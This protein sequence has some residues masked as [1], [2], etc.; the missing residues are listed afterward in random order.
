MTS[1][2]VSAS[3]GALNLIGQHI[4]SLRYNEH[5][6]RMLAAIQQLFSRHIHPELQPPQW[7]LDEKG[8]PMQLSAVLDWPEYIFQILQE[9]PP[10]PLFYY[11][12]LFAH[13]IGDH[14]TQQQSH[15]LLRRKK[16]HYIEQFYMELMHWCLE[17]FSSYP[18]GNASKEKILKRFHYL[19]ACMDSPC[20]FEEN[21]S[22]QFVSHDNDRLILKKLKTILS[23]CLDY[24]DIEIA[25]LS[26]REYLSTLR[27]HLQQFFVHTIN[28]IYHQQK[29]ETT[30]HLDVHQLVNPQSHYPRLLHED[31]KPN[32]MNQFLYDIMR[33]LN[34]QAFHLVQSSHPSALENLDI[35]LIKKLMA[36][37]DLFPWMIHHESYLSQFPEIIKLLYLFNQQYE[38]LNIVFDLTG[39]MGEFW[40][41]THEQGGEILSKVISH[42]KAS[43][44]R[45]YSSAEF[46]HQ[47]L[48]RKSEVY[49]HEKKTSIDHKFYKQFKKTQKYFDQIKNN[50][51]TIREHCIFIL[52][53]VTSYPKNKRREINEKIRKI[54]K[55]LNLDSLSENIPPTVEKKP[56][57]YSFN[58]I[59]S[60]RENLKEVTF[61][62][63]NHSVQFLGNQY[64]T[65]TF[66]LHFFNRG[67]YYQQ[68]FFTGFSW[69]QQYKFRMNWDLRIIYLQGFLKSLHQAKDYL[70]PF[71]HEK[72]LWLIENLLMWGSLE[73]ENHE[74]LS[75]HLLKIK[76]SPPKKTTREINAHKVTFFQKNTST[77]PL[78]PILQ[79]QNDLQLEKALSEMSPN[80]CIALIQNIH[81]QH[82]NSS[83]EESFLNLMMRQHSKSPMIE[84]L[85]TC[86]HSL[87]S[88]SLPI[89]EALTQYHQRN[90]LILQ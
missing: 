73:K 32:S 15:W 57:I 12:Q 2:T 64:H 1:T 46:L 65:G 3:V 6:C 28:W 69:Y 52:D 25:R 45:L 84:W 16:G 38:T 89:T 4:F 79:I 36:K 14:L 43:I 90:W 88:Q 83:K 85:L 47:E 5:E 39:E 55:D 42:I 22:F 37:E 29:N 9:K 86:M 49:F 75:F 61:S 63:K 20:I 8:C 80:T 78:H 35:S 50:K 77:P 40:A 81:E 33:F 10:S 66:S 7:Q 27:A 21:F 18:I 48:S 53:K 72:S 59:E 76:S 60:I 11:I 70:Y 23:Q 87:K 74:K 24:M 62:I 44:E 82:Q 71:F 34:P 19:D 58:D 51:E 30:T 13:I 17:D 54:K 56:K 68:L 67:K 26:A 41:Y 31:K